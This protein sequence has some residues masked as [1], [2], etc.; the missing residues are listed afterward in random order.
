ML[1]I[2]FAVKSLIFILIF[3]TINPLLTSLATDYFS[4]ELKQ[5]VE[6][7]YRAYIYALDAARPALSNEQWLAL[8]KRISEQSNLTV[9]TI[10][11]P[12]SEQT[13]TILVENVHDGNLQAVTAKIQGNELIQFSAFRVKDNVETIL[14]FI[15]YGLPLGLILFLFLLHTLWL[16]YRLFRLELASKLIAKGQLSGRADTGLFAIGRVN[17]TF[18]HM[19]DKLERLFAQQRHMIRAI[20]HE[21]KTPIFRLQLKLE[22]LDKSSNNEKLIYELFEEC[23]ELDTLVHEIL[24]YS[25]VE[26]FSSSLNF[27]EINL[28]NSLQDYAKS[29]EKYCNHPI[30]LD[31]QQSI[32]ARVDN[33][34]IKRVIHNLVVNADKYAVDLIHVSLLRQGRRLLLTVEDD[35]IGIAKGKREL[36]FQPFYTVDE[37][38]TGKRHGVGL[39]LAI[40]KEILSSHDANVKI[41]KSQF[42]GACLTIDLSS[43]FVE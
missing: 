39:G 15:Q 24:E 30:I 28:S 16:Q 42:G 25:K 14:F 1:L 20:S 4:T 21:L 35:G 13:Q 12:A 43:C 33:A 37:S 17:E 38:R 2:R 40:V 29:I 23:D 27:T 7:D 26:Q 32:F 8:L 11:T 31:V 5:D 3:L 6:L 34:G 19:A 9:K 22:L 36:V 18:N 10:S 41:R